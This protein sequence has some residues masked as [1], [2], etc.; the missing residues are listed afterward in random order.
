[1]A[2][3]LTPSQRPHGAQFLLSATTLACE[4]LIVLFAALVSHQLAPG[5]R[6]AVWTFSLVVAVALLLCTGLL[7][8][9][10]WP[11]VLGAV[12]Q[13]AMILL[14]LVV[15][16]MWV[17]GAL[18]AALYLFGVLKGH[19]LDAQKDAIDAEYWRE[20]PEDAPQPAAGPG[21]LRDDADGHAQGAHRDQDP[22]ASRP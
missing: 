3:D 4:S 2:L 8:R 13:V 14:G 19:Q 21:P 10:A 17:L 9:K 6:T 1:M 16:A 22:D 12:L 20:H 15:P 11:Y 18:M 7:R 5:H